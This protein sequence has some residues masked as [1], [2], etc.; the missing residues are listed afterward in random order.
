[1]KKY[2]IGVDQGN[3]KTET[4]LCDLQGTIVGIGRSRGGYAM[5]DM[6]S[7]MAEIEQAVTQALASAGVASNQVQLLYG[8]ITSADWPDEHETIRQAVAALGLAQQVVIA[9]DS[10]IALRGGTDAPYGAIIVAGSGANCMLRAPD[11]RTFHYHYYVEQELQGG[12]ALGRAALT[13]IYRAHTG[14]EPLT[15]LTDLVLM[16]AKQ[17]NVDALL[18]ADSEGTLSASRI[19]QIAPLVFAAADAG[20]G[21]AHQ[22]LVQFGEGLAELVTAQVVQMDLQNRAFDVVTSG[23]IFKGRGRLLEE[24]IA[25]AIAQGAPQARLVNARYEPVVGAVL[26][27]L[28]ELQIEISPAI[29]KQIDA[30]AQ[31]WGLLREKG[32]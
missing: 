13:K 17:P 11:G 26:L 30:S 15:A 8:G 32:E 4:A 20:D 12:H 18:R 22:I 16:H 19:R 31:Q 1:M 5:R 23:S 7:T 29:K 3:S 27:G 24:T 9:N 10:L 14:R 2:V 21:V 25:R 28:E 6:A